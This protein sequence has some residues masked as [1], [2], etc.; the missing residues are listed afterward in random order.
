M[1]Y[2]DSPMKPAGTV[3]LDAPPPLPKEAKRNAPKDWMNTQSTDAGGLGAAAASP[4]VQVMSAN[5]KIEEAFQMLS[6]AVPQ[7]AGDLQQ[8]QQVFSQAATMALQSL[9]S[10]DQSPVGAPQPQG[11]L[12]ASPMPPMAPPGA[13]AGGA[14]GPQG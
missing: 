10:P 12:M 6:A 1:A 2:T 3:L 5:Q 4:I 7:M 9:T 13:G 8:L 11:G 14:M